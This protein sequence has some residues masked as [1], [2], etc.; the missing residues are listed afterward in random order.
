MVFYI[1]PISFHYSTL[2]T[3][4]STIRSFAP[5]E[6]FGRIRVLQISDLLLR[7]NRNDR[8]FV[9]CNHD[10]RSVL[11]RWNDMFLV[12]LVFLDFKNVS[13]FHA[14]LGFFTGETMRDTSSRGRCCIKKTRNLVNF[15]F[16]HYKRYRGF[17]N[18]RIGFV[19]KLVF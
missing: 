6:G 15:G 10:A 8:G 12:N 9:F 19:S 3:P 7:V 11:M 14:R 16:K 18:L 4:V 2:Y 1:F 17:K 5:T 13:Y